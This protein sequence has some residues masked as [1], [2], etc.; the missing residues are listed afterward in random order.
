MS[1]IITTK[2]DSIE[3]VDADWKQLRQRRNPRTLRSRLLFVA[4]IACVCGAAGTVAHIQYRQGAAAQVLER[5]LESISDEARVA[6]AALK[7]R[8][9]RLARIESVRGSKEREIHLG[10]VWSALTDILSD[11][12]SI[13]DLQF[14]DKH[15]SLTGTT[16]SASKLIELLDASPIFSEPEFRGPVVKVIE[17]EGERFTLDIGIEN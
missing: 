4:H 7:E 17:G 2:V 16:S 3:V 12:T 9:F 5:K 15:I 6:E 1:L 14:D 11:D 8:Q 13:T 10:T